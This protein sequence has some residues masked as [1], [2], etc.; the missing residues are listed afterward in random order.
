MFSTL[1][2]KW[3]GL[4]ICSD[5]NLLHHM[6]CFDAE[7]PFQHEAYS[8]GGVETKTVGETQV[9]FVVVQL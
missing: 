4:V 9:P 8:D 2:D 5:L 3:K 7:I 6:I 1:R